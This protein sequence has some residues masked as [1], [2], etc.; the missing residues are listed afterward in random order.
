MSWTWD[1]VFNKYDEIR[2]SRGSRVEYAPSRCLYVIYKTKKENIEAVLPEPLEPGPEPLVQV[3]ILDLNLPGRVG[4]YYEAVVCPLAKYEDKTGL[5]VVSAYVDSESQ[6][7]AIG[8]VTFARLFVGYPKL[9]A[10]ISLTRW[11]PMAIGTLER[12]PGV[13]LMK[14][15]T[16]LEKTF[17]EGEAKLLPPGRF[18]VRPI[19]RPDT[20]HPEI[21]QLIYA[22]AHHEPGECYGGNAIVSF[23]KDPLDPIYILEPTEIIGGYY[24]EQLKVTFVPGKVIYY[25]DI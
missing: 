9:P 11:G 6:R 8:V 23:E 14:L 18:A 5:F 1:F 22:E 20:V 25:T 16:T 12:E 3:M 10:K 19:P 2:R 17:N 24:S 13:K 21:K 4:Q 15:A 7:G